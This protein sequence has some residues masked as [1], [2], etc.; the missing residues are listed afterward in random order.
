M[1]DQN[2]YS[3][4][5]ERIFESKFA[6]GLREVE[7]KRDDVERTAQELGVP[8]PKNIGDMIYPFCFPAQLPA[9]IR[10]H[11]PK[12]E[13]WVIRLAGRARYRFVVVR[14]VPLVP[15]QRMVV[16]K[17]LDATPG[18][19][20]KYAFNDEQALLAKVRYNRLVDIFTGV[21]CYSLQ[22]HLRTTVPGIGQ[23]ETDELYVGVDKKGVHYVFPMQAKGGND[24]LSVVQVEQDPGGMRPQ[25]PVASVQAYRRPVHGGRYHCVVR[26]RGERERDWHRRGEALQV[27]AAGRGE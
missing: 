12:G 8:R 27:G 23:V 19:V 24:K 22:N 10:K 16:A 13:P 20:A 6:P 14:D 3:Q 25:M 15:N 5:I 9:A 18:L 4:L 2:L 11:A 17:V 7:F 26:V 21:A 1:K